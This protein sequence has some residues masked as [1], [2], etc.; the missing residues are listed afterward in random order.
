MTIQLLHRMFQKNQEIQSKILV[1][2][3][4]QLANH[5]EPRSVD[6]F[7]MVDALGLHALLLGAR[8]RQVTLLDPLFKIPDSERYESRLDIL[9]R[10]DLLP[11][12]KSLH[13]TQCAERGAG[14]IDFLVSIEPQTRAASLLLEGRIVNPFSLLTTNE[15]GKYREESELITFI[16]SFPT[17]DRTLTDASLGLVHSIDDGIF[18]TVDWRSEEHFH[19]ETPLTRYTLSLRPR[20]TTLVFPLGAPTL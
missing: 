15:L 8:E 12:E 11:D 1:E 7:H 4:L 2:S 14:S 19:Y 20:P 17:E 6:S 13:R 10:N 18:E 16:V 9:A 3:S 5:S